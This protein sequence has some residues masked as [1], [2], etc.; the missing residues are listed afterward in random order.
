MLWGVTFIQNCPSGMNILNFPRSHL[1]NVEAL[2]ALCIISLIRTFEQQQKGFQVSQRVAKIERFQ[3]RYSKQIVTSA[4]AS[5]AWPGAG[6][7]RGRWWGGECGNER[8]W[9]E[10]REGGEGGGGRTTRW[11][12]G[13]W[14]RYV[15]C[16]VTGAFHEEE[17]CVMVIITKHLGSKEWSRIILFW[18]TCRLRQ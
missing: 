11:G 8:R 17:P 2:Y 9:E 14:C 1:P 16:D 12:R 13:L 10:G 7:G 18:D 6:G 4:Q 5:P 3:V 15:F